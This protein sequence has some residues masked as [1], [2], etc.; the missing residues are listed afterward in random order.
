M[1]ISANV[2]NS[3]YA[4]SVV[5]R[6]NEKVQAIPIPGKATGY[7]S[8]VNGGELL[9]LALATCFCNDLY[10]EA[11]KR[12]I[13]LTHVAVE[14]SG[15]FVQEGAAGTNLVYKARIEGDASREELD[16]LLKHTDQVAEIQNTLRAGV[17][18][19]RVD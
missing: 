9:M 1:K 15:E 14:A 16:V 19:E 10:R 6:T 17:R 4:H 3:A 11:Q 5:V 12:G 7:G 8:A 18:V 2:E 13:T